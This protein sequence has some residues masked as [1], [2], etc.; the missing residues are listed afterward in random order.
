MGASGRPHL[1][2]GRL[3]GGGVGEE[4][5]HVALLGRRDLHAGEHGEALAGGL[6][7]GGDVA[8]AV[9]V[10]DGDHGQA[11][12]ERRVDDRRRRHLVVRAGRQRRVDVQVCEADV[13]AWFPFTP[14]A[15][16]RPTMSNVSAGDE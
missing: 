13:H 14:R 4:A 12:S 8:R 15:Y 3:R 11:L 9:V 2:A 6:L 1:G 7:D 5:D 10:A 16:R